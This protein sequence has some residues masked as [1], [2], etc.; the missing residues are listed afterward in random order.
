MKKCNVI[1]SS[2]EFYQFSSY[3]N[4]SFT[5]IFGKLLPNLENSRYVFDLQRIFLTI[6]VTIYLQLL[7]HYI[8]VCD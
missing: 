2:K 4:I 7:S 3:F 5:T 1:F 8:A 6:T